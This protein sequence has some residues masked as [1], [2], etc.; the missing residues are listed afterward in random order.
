MCNMP[1]V[2]WQLKLENRQAT[3]QEGMT[4]QLKDK[5]FYVKKPLKKSFSDSKH[6]CDTIRFCL[7]NVI[8]C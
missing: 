4:L 7:K 3:D 5:V 8:L 6:G 1:C 2:L